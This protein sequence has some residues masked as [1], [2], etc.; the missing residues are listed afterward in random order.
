MA[1]LE[2]AI[3]VSD[4]WA[5]TRARVRS[6]ILYDAYRLVIARRNELA[7]LMSLELGRALP[8]SHGELTCGAV[9][10]RWFAE[11]AVRIGGR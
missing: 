3:S 8:D 1:A 2:N 9:F 7:A 10:L 5:T 6:S 4:T 11:E